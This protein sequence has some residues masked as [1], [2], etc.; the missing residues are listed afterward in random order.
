MFKVSLGVPPRIYLTQLRIERACELLEKTGL[1]V[2]EVAQEVGYSSSQVLAR[3]FLKHRK[4]SP[5]DYRRAVCDPRR[6]FEHHES[7]A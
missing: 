2:M 3:V 1:S 6:L 5:S 7:R 4:M